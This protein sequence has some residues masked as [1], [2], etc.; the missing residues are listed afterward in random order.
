MTV[1][2]PFCHLVVAPDDP[3]KQL[4]SDGRSAHGSCC[5]NSNAAVQVMQRVAEHRYHLVSLAQRDRRRRK[6]S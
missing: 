1:Y 2:C 5:R 3:E 6:V 4:L